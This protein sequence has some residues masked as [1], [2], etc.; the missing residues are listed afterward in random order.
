MPVKSQ[1][2]VIPFFASSS[3]AAYGSRSFAISNRDLVLINF[4]PNQNVRILAGSACTDRLARNLFSTC[5]FKI[6]IR[7]EIL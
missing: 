3:H 6:K 4:V 1:P 7:N 5:L 2:E